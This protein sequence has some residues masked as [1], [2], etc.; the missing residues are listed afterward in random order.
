MSKRS[1]KLEG[2]T[3][4][5]F[6]E[7]SF[8]L[9]LETRAQE[10]ELSWTDYLRE[11]LENP[12][13][14]NNRSAAVKEALISHL[15]K[16]YEGLMRSTKHLC[17]STWL[18]EQNGRRERFH[19]L[20]E[21]I[22]VGQDIHADIVV[23]DSSVAAKHLIL[24]NDSQKWWAVNINDDK[25]CKINNK[26]FTVNPVVRRSEITFGNCQLIKV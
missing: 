20:R 16:D 13:A 11:L 19:L 24:V 14:N 26:P 12:S 8:W 1:I 15:R 21:R 10:A 7:D 22:V 18:L 4:S 5:I 17:E 3:T 2:K 25:D 6:L 9:E 23:H